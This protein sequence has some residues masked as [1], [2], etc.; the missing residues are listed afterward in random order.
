MSEDS[1]GTTFG[2]CVR[3]RALYRGP[4]HSVMS[5]ARHFL[6]N[7]TF[8]YTFR[9]WSP[10]RVQQSEALYLVQ[11]RRAPSGLASHCDWV[12]GSRKEHWNQRAHPHFTVFGDPSVVPRTVFVQTDEL[13]TFSNA[14]LPCFPRDHRFVLISGDHDKTTPRQ[15]D[16][17]YAPVLLPD[18]WEQWQRDPRIAHIFVEHLDVRPS[19]KVSGIPLGFNP[20]EL[21]PD[22]ALTYAQ[23]I[24]P[25]SQ[26][27]LRA[28]DASRDRFDGRKYV[29]EAAKNASPPEERQWLERHRAAQA[30]DAASWCDKLA[31]VP[32]HHYLDTIQNYSFVLCAH[33]GGIDPNPKL[34]T[35]LAAGA[36]PIIRVEPEW[37]FASVYEGWPV[38]RLEKWADI[39]R[40][41]LEEWR[42]IHA[43]AFEDRQLREQL[44]E[45][46][47]ARYW[48]KRINSHLP[49]SLKPD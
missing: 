34:F 22:F 5:D 18:T 30:C 14:M 24:A 23:N 46:L 41:K 4:H 20:K 15:L 31:S 3:S 38:V 26:R 11:S 37:G 28:L 12:V 29:S 36:I 45:R 7:E 49:S 13:Q 9:A 2:A 43:P 16:L 32:K 47:R 19:T 48:W 6:G 33:G 35:V 42:V 39:T 44:L 27:P 25:I 10:L 17:R 21:D 8:R 1:V 40:A